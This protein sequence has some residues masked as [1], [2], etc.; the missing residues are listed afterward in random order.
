MSD[1]ERLLS[2]CGGVVG[3]SASKFPEVIG[4]R[5]HGA[6]L[7]RDTSFRRMYK[8]FNGY[9]PDMHVKRKRPLLRNS[10]LL[11]H[12]NARPYFAHCVLDVSQQNN[13]EILPHPPYTPVKTPCDF[14]LFPQLKK[15]LRGKRFASNKSFVKTDDAILINLLENGHLHV[16]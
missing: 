16:F 1:I 4:I 14:W 11:H 7:K 12:D 13:I 10:F 5:L 8:V 6:A 15:P 3:N 2:K 9:T